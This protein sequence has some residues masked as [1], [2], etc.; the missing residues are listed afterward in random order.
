MGSRLVTWPLP[1]TSRLPSGTN[2]RDVIVRAD[3]YPSAIDPAEPM[4]ARQDDPVQQAA[5][6]SWPSG[7]EG[8]WRVAAVVGCEPAGT[9]VRVESRSTASQELDGV[10]FFFHSFRPPLARWMCGPH[11]A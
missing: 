5:S 11:L 8:M 10:R 6:D 3:P 9:V 4:A 2:L 7:P 1:V